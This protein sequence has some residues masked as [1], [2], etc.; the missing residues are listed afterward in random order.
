MYGRIY[1]YNMYVLYIHNIIICVLY[2][3]TYDYI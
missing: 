3:Y 1:D 2:I